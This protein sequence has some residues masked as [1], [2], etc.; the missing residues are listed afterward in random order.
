METIHVKFDEL[1][2]MASKCNNLELGINCMNFQDSSEDLQSISSKSDLD[3]LFGSMYEEYYATSSQ[4]VSDNSV[5]NTLDNDHTSSS[6]SIV[7]EEDESPQIVSSSVEQVTTK[8]NSLVLNENANE[9]HPSNMHEFHQN[10]TQVIVS[11]IKPKNIKEAMLDTSCIES[12][13]DELN[14][15][16]RLDVWKLVECPIGK[17]IITVKWIWKNKIDAKNTVTYNKSHLVAKGYRQEEEI[18]FEESFSPVARLEA[19]RIL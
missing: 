6:S 7:V 16:K 8:P 12:M 2:E 18:D 3:N 11:T 4:E 9:L 1:I 14:L 10:I 13:Q 5:A 17:K 19:V 15:F